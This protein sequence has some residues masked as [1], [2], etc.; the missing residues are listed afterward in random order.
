MQLR[1]T[2]SEDHN[3]PQPATTKRPYDTP[4]LAEYGQVAKLTQGGGSIA[5]DGIHTAMHRV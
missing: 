1:D 4:V 5:V 3:S 2:G